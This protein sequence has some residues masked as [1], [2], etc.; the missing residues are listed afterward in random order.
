VGVAA[1]ASSAESE[2]PDDGLEAEASESSVLRAVA[3]PRRRAILRLVASQELSAGEIASTFDVSRPAVSQ[4]L[5]VL[6]DAGLLVE[7]REGT[8][9]LYRTRAAG[10]SGLRRFL[11]D[12]WGN[13]LADAARIAEAGADDR[14]AVDDHGGQREHRA[15]RNGTTGE[16]AR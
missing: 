7:R 4:H 13:A 15:G 12:L 8:R 16:E 11:D 5:T 10:L 9:R 2:P 6:K 3:E 1:P 14:G